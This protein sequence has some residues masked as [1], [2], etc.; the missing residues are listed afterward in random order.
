MENLTVENGSTERPPLADIHNGYYRVHY[1]KIDRL[2]RTLRK[3]IY[4]GQF[5]ARIKDT[6]YPPL[7]EEPYLAEVLK[8]TK[9]VGLSADIANRYAFRGSPTK[10]DVAILIK[11]S[12]PAYKSSQVDIVNF[13]VAPREFVGIV[14]PDDYNG[15]GIRELFPDHKEFRRFV[16]KR[17][18][19]IKAILAE[20]RVNLPVYGSTGDLYW[21]E[22]I[23]HDQIAH[24]KPS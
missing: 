3:G 14:T 15:R 9:T 8:E 1:T 5:A 21:P 18:E 19:E 20:T 12:K 24:R 4:S 13:R 6:E 22:R 10:D 17:V 7:I 16:N 23:S 11:R 2:P